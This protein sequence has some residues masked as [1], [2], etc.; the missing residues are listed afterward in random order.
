MAITDLG[1]SLALLT[2]VKG[3]GVQSTAGKNLTAHQAVLFTDTV[4]T[5]DTLVGQAA[6]GTILVLDQLAS[7]ADIGRFL[8]N[9]ATRRVNAETTDLSPLESQGTIEHLVSGMPKLQIKG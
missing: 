7:R 1:R 4:I 5:T 6:L 9:G 2:L 3:V 8:F